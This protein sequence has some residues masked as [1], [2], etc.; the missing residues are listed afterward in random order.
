M[1]ASHFR[2]N[3]S[4]EA[5]TQAVIVRQ[6]ASLSTFLAKALL[7]AKRNLMRIL[8][9]ALGLLAWMPGQAQNE[10]VLQDDAVTMLI[11][12]GVNSLPEVQELNNRYDS[13]SRRVQQT[14][15]RVIPPAASFNPGDHTPL[16]KVE[17]GYQGSARFQPHLY[18]FIDTTN[19]QLFVEDLVHGD[20]P[21]IE[22][23][24]LR[25]EGRRIPENSLQPVLEE[26]QARPEN[27]P[28][29]L[30]KNDP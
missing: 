26:A 15:I 28:E 5:R 16:Y 1:C 8:L 24:R 13:V 17:V 18:L 7:T 27:Q 12:K 10:T 2:L 9:A 14:V 6:S 20:R 23:W 19:G 25:Q 22:E 4:G 29:I 30:D 11:K 21:T 3:G